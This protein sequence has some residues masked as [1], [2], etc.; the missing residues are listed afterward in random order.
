MDLILRLCCVVSLTGDARTNEKGVISISL[1]VWYAIRRICCA[2]E[3]LVTCYARIEAESSSSQGKD[4]KILP[5][6]ECH[7]FRP[8]EAHGNVRGCYSSPYQGIEPP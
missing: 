7:G 4:I 6:L 2:E 8:Q 5:I 3:R 1:L